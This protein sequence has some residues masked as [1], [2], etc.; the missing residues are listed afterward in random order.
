MRIGNF[1]EKGVLPEEGRYYWRL[2]IGR[3]ACPYRLFDGGWHAF[4]LLVLKKYE[5]V[6]DGAAHP[7]LFR[8]AFAFWFPFYFL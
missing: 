4:E 2:A 7:T 6:E 8:I 5:V 1:P 3:D